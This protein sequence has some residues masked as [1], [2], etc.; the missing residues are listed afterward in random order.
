MWRPRPVTSWDVAALIAG[1]S[2]VA[3]LVGLLSNAVPRRL[4]AAVA[5]IGLGLAFASTGHASAAQPQW[6]TRPLVFI[7]VVTIAMWVGALLPLVL[8]SRRWTVED[9]RTLGR[10][11]RFIPIPVTAIVVAGIGL[12]IVQVERP[13]ALLTTAYGWVLLAKLVLLVPL[14]ALA[15]ANRWR[16]TERVSSGD[17]PSLA[18]LRRSMVLELAIVLAIF[19]VVGLWRF[20]P[21]PRSMDMAAEQPVVVHLHSAQA[22]VGVSVAPDRAGAVDITLQVSNADFT[23]LSAKEVDV[24]LSLPDGGIEPIRRKAQFH[25]GL[26]TVENVLLPAAGQWTIGVGVLV[27]DFDIVRLDGTLRILP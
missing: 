25:D 12:A 11:S 18:R 2:A 9:A 19:A 1:L 14:F 22:M 17:M 3:A 5:L 20:T 26:W 8:L 15:A 10:F 6:L 7:H 16:F 27:T 4:M 13:S 21:P 23:P 24:T